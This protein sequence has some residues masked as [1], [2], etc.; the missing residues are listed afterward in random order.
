[1]LAVIPTV[2][3]TPCHSTIQ[4]QH[5]ISHARESN[6]SSRFTLTHTMRAVKIW[7]KLLLF[8]RAQLFEG[9]LVLNPLTWLS[10]FCSKAFSQIIF[11][12]VCKSIQSLTCWQKEL[13][14]IYFLSFQIWIQIFALT[15][16]YLNPAL[17]NPAQDC[18]EEAW[19][20]ALQC[21][22]LICY[23]SVAFIQSPPSWNSLCVHL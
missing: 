19:P 15:L 13:N 3:I 17:N 14:W 1:M 9:R 7:V 12:V 22:L 11:S 6:F 8:F 16:G 2:H 18:K 23:P 5:L 4:Q 20:L 21:L 10:F